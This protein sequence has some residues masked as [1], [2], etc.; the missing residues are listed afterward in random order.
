VKAALCALSLA[1]TLVGGAATADNAGGTVR[2]AAAGAT[3][4]G[5]E[6]YGHICQGCHQAD[7]R[8]AVGAGRYP[9]LAGDPALVAW[10][11]VAVTVLLGRHAMPAF[12]KPTDPTFVF[13]EVHLSDAEIAEVVNYVRSHFGNHY[14]ERTTA[15]KIAALPHPLN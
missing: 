13:G 3:R 7:A 12:G 15:E 4:S 8:G 9:A 5:A 10:E 11:Y 14:R 2:S 1:L 6:I